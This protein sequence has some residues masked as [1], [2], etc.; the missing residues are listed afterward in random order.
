M[1]DS[2]L[3]TVDLISGNWTEFAQYFLGITLPKYTHI[4]GHI[5]Q[6]IEPD[7]LFPQEPHLND[8]L[9][10]GEGI[11]VRLVY[12]RQLPDNFMDIGTMRSIFDKNGKE[13]Q[14]PALDP[15]YYSS[16][17]ISTYLAL[18]PLP[19]YLKQYREDRLEYKHRKDLI[20]AQ[21]NDVHDI[22]R[23]HHSLDS[24]NNILEHPTFN[25]NL[26]ADQYGKAVNFYRTSEIVHNLGNARLKS[27][28]LSQFLRLTL[29]DQSSFATFVQIFRQYL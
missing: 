20:L 7:F 16:R 5:A 18:L 23:L 10:N 26:T 4:Y 25:K 28:R 15:A 21:D 3:C 2:K 14:I 27:Q 17:Q 12:P 9:Y 19:D 24:V 29:D 6:N 8:L 13:L 1:A 11:A 22:L